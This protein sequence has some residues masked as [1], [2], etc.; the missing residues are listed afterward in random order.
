[1]YEAGLG[2]NNDDGDGGNMEGPLDGK[3]GGP[4]DG[5]EG[6]LVGE[7]GNADG[8]GETVKLGDVGCIIIG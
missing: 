7:G 3:A 4:I 5:N 1:M 8:D 6:G 2:L